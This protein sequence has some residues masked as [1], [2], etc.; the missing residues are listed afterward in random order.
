[1]NKKNAGVTDADIID[2]FDLQ[3]LVEAHRALA[4]AQVAPQQVIA[5]IEQHLTRK[6]QIGKGDQVDI[7]TGTITRAK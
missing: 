3:T 2:A 5:A 7:Q 6:Y 1:M 4:S